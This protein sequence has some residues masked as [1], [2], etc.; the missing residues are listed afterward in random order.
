MFETCIM[1]H[2]KHEP[3]C[4]A[5]ACNHATHFKNTIYL[6]FVVYSP[7]NIEQQ[8]LGHYLSV[9][10]QATGFAEKT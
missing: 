1:S 10:P 5:F 2:Q 6:L 8:P 7:Q 3:M 4:I 9:Q